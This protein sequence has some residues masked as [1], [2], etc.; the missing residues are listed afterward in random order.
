VPWVVGPNVPSGKCYSR[1]YMRDVLRTLIEEMVRDLNTNP[2]ATHPE[3]LREITAISPHTILPLP[4][5]EPLE[6]Y[7]C[8]M[9]ALG[10]VGK[11]GE[12]PHPLLA[13]T[14]PFVNYLIDNALQ[15]CDPKIGALVVWSSAGVIRHIGKLIALCRA[16]SKWGHGI[17]CTHGLE[18]L[19]QRYGDVSGYYDATQCDSVLVHL[20]NFVFGTLNA[21][22]T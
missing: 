9:H 3:R 18:E 16:E 2:L 19:P 1:R 10:L 15:P 13:A 17:L 20:R 6:K 5:A 21:D 4:S 8:V 14:T 11:M 22:H 7:N 12:Y